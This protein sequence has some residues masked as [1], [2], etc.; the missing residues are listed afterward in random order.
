MRW[1]LVV[2]AGCVATAEPVQTRVVSADGLRWIEIQ[3]AGRPTGLQSVDLWG[4][5]KTSAH[6][7]LTRLAAGL[8]EPA[9]TH[10]RTFR[11]LIVAGAMR[12]VI[13]GRRSEELGPGSY[14]VI[15]AGVIHFAQCTAATACEV[16]VE[17]D[18]PLDVK[19]AR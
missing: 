3:S 1:L 16:Y 10:A 14:V 2:L 6:G 19:L 9:H 4:D 15:G 7:T 8:S 17:Q 11:S 18:G 5:A 12:Y 13:D